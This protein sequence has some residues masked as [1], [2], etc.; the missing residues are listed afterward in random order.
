MT[1]SRADFRFSPRPN[2]AAEIDWRPWGEA[3][4]A[5]ARSLGRPVLLSLSAVW[6]HW[7]HVMDETSYSD[8]RVI[9][10][11]NRDYLPVRVDNDR[12]PDVNRRYNMGGWPTTAFLT[13]GGE[14]LT[15]ATYLPPDD[16]AAALEKVRAYFDEHRDELDALDAQ[17]AA[18]RERA[19]AAVSAAAGESAAAREG[20]PKRG[21]AGVAGREAGAPV[22]EHVDEASVFAGDASGPG[23]LA[24]QVALTIVRAFDPLHGGLGSEPKFPQADVFGFLL[25]YAGL[26]GGSGSPLLTRSRLD[27][28]LR[29][30]LTSMAAGDVYDRVGEGFFRYAT[31]R[32]WAVPHYEKML[33]DNARLALLY[34]DAALA[35]D[36]HGGTAEPEGTA[37][38]GGTA[39]PG[40]TD[41]PTDARDGPEAAGGQAGDAARYRRTAFGVID[42]LLGTLWR[43][44]PPVFSGS[45]DAD[46]HYYT[47]D[48]AGRSELAAP[49]IDTTVYVD[50]NA[51]AARALL[52]GAA[53]LARPELARPA[54]DLLDHL[55]GHARRD[56]ALVHYLTPEGEEGATGGLLGDQAAV[57]TALLDA[58]EVSGRDDL[59]GRAEA[60]A[61]WVGERLGTADGRLLDR[62]PDPRAGGLLA[63]P[64][65]S[66]EDDAVMADVLLRLEAYTGEPGYRRRALALL[67]AWVPHVAGSG[68]GA[69]PYA[70]ALLRA[71][72]RPDHLVVV[73]HDGDGATDAL[74]AAALTA[75][76][77][78][79]TVQRLDPDRDAGRLAARGLPAAA[80]GAG[81]TRAAGAVYVCRGTS[82]LAPAFSPDELRERLTTG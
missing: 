58:Y 2:R 43:G 67:A 72:E 69:A 5:E 37:K 38:A 6:C 17:R 29:V 23:D 22:L 21:A 70:A 68:V 30:T 76:R 15:G 1:A 79:R 8:P 33:E 53:V 51:L 35:T 20:A 54:V 63:R 42:Y 40:G 59:L 44:E 66:L 74:H 47:L 61:D 56:G 16:M 26:R 24:D 55:W 57:A 32:D 19:A 18:E 14:V 34:L 77:P 31:Q 25:A 81:M 62:E 64:L 50:W 13:G 45:Q 4:F 73:G 12:D 3:A 9:E 41:E 82:C 71:L 46:E 39:E 36:G 75:P 28:V 10:R 27:E 52:R 78:L 7:C 48:A 60:L 65:P 11:V 49:F 80:G